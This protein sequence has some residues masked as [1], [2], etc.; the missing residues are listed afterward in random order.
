MFHDKTEV[1]IKESHRHRHD[2]MSYE[3]KEK[4]HGGHIGTIVPPALP[5][6]GLGSPFAPPVLPLPLAGPVVGPTG[7]HDKFSLKIKEKVH[8][9]RKPAVTTTT[10]TATPAGMVSETITNTPFMAP[11]GGIGMP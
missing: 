1:S 2:K 5:S 10:T 8:G 7:R 6:A 9:S 4:H 11:V 3:V